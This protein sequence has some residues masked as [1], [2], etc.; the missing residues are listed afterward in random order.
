MILQENRT[1]LCLLLLAIMVMIYSLVTSAPS[2]PTVSLSWCMSAL[3]SL[4]TSALSAAIEVCC[5][6]TREKLVRTCLGFRDL[7]S[8]RCHPTAGDTLT[9]EHRER[10]AGTQRQWQPHQSMSKEK[11]TTEKTQACHRSWLRGGAVCSSLRESSVMS[12]SSLKH[13]FF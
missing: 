6:V 4:Q 1:L 13:L 3:A 9:R 2:A 12:C 7:L 8:I 10:Q 5:F 11:K